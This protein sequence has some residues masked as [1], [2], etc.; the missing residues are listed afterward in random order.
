MED[1]IVYIIWYTY[2]RRAETLASEL[3]AKIFF[4]Y[5]A[6]LINKYLKP[7]RFLV[8]AWKTWQLLDRERPAFVIAQSPPIFAPMTVALWCKLRGR[9]R[10][11]YII[12]CHPGNF[13]D[14]N[15]HWALP[16]LHR[17][18]RGALVSLLCNEDAQNTMIAWNC[19]HIFL[20][21]GLP[22][23]PAPTGT[24][25]SGGEVRM[26]VIS[27]FNADEPIDTLFDAARLMPQVTFYVTGNPQRAAKELLADKPSNVILTGF[28]RGGIYSGLLHNIQGILVLSTLE[29]T[30][31]CGAFEALSL[32]KPTIVSDLLEMRRW[33]S[34]AFVMV[35][36]TPEDMVRG[37]ETVVSEYTLLID[38]TENLRV[39]YL[40][41]RQP[42]LQALASLLQRDGHSIISEHEV[43]G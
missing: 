10:A 25:G 29:T 20:P 16:L 35:K 24:M 9:K 8:Q 40:A 31:S 41:K 23:L 15:W 30:L 6:R 19:K 13:Y 18:A 43:C 38:K 36:N 34:S 3:N 22:T 5:E 2:A 4:I 28:L 7:L 17:L 1:K 11:R 32:A 33:F 39:E 27:T 37:V 14:Q 21:D 42:K 26:A 12:D